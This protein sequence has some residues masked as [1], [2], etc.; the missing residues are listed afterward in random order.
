MTATHALFND[1]MILDGFDGFD[2][3]QPIN[4]ADSLRAWLAGEPVT[5]ERAA[6]VIADEVASRIDGR[7]G[8]PFTVDV[9]RELFADIR[10]AIPGETLNRNAGLLAAWLRDEPGA[11]DATAER[12]VRRECDARTKRVVGRIV[13]R[14][15]HYIRPGYPRSVLAAD[16]F[17][18]AFGELDTVVACVASIL[19]AVRTAFR[20]GVRV[21]A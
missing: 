3:T 2:P 14:K 5:D 6:L 18:E 19:N 16:T 8:G 12:A 15:A 11:D 21:A 7:A 10:N 17:C 4:D 20:A 9:A 1:A 13:A